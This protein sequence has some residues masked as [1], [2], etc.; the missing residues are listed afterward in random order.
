MI[1][2]H[3]IN[4]PSYGIE[5]VDGINETDKRLILMDTL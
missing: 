3:G 4:A 5:V 1:I 2:D